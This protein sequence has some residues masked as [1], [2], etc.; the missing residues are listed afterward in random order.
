[1]FLHAYTGSAEVWEKQIPAFTRAGYR[2]IAYERRGFGRTVAE[3]KGPPFTG[4]DDRR[5]PKNRQF[6]LVGTASGGFVALDFV[7]SS[8]TRAQLYPALLTGW[9]AGRGLPESD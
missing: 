6:H 5:S 7:I 4:T 3:A 9:R 1:M 8:A 2:L